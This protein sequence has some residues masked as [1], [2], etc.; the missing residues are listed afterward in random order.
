MKKYITM[1]AVSAG[2]LVASQVAMAESAVPVANMP[3]QC[4][5]MARK[6]FRINSETIT[7]TGTGATTPRAGSSAAPRKYGEGGNDKWFIDSFPAHPKGGCRVCGVT[8]AVKGT[9]SQTSIN[10]DSITIVGS[11][12]SAPQISV[13]P[14]PAHFDQVHLRLAGQSPLPQGPYSNAFQIDGPAYM[15]WYMAALAPSLDVMVQDDTSVS[16]IEVTYFYY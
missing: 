5:E 2:V 14:M 13:T 10:N 7:R 3:K 12:T 6:G 9:V 15:S 16:M 1:L 8:V 11:N 4:Q